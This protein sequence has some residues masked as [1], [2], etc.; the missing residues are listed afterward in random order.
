VIIRVIVC[1]QKPSHPFLQTFR[2]LG[3][4]KDF[5]PA[6]VHFIRNNCLFCLLWLIS[7]RAD[8]IG[9][10][11]KFCSMVELLHEL[12]TAIF[13]REAFRHL[14]MSQQGKSKTKFS[15]LPHTDYC[16]I[17]SDA[18]KMICVIDKKRMHGSVI[19][20][21]ILGLCYIEFFDEL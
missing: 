16:K 1:V 20:G 2:A 11:T 15:L 14:I 13:N 9:Y 19:T 18:L 4:L 10:I 7:A 3:M 21:K 6:I 17:F 12:Q 5:F 8:R